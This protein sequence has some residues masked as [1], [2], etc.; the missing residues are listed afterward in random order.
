[1]RLGTL[2][3]YLGKGRSTAC[4][5]RSVD[6]CR[7]WS[8]RSRL[9]ARGWGCREVWRLWAWG[10]GNLR[11][12]QAVGRTELRLLRPK[13][14]L[15][16][17]AQPRRLFAWLQNFRRLVIRYERHAANFLG[18]LHPAAHSSSCGSLEMASSAIDPPPCSE[19]DARA[20]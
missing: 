4:L 8:P 16:E 5:V 3:A 17:L 12:E 11:P 14:A 7:A 15:S 6:G 10:C 20:R 1:M 13:R 18:F 9:Q 2:G 19:T